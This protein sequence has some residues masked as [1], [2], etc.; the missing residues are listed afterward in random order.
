MNIIKLLVSSNDST[1]LILISSPK[2]IYYDNLTKSEFSSNY[3]A[4]TLHVSCFFKYK[5]G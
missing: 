4:Y 1:R 5:P 3:I 2:Q